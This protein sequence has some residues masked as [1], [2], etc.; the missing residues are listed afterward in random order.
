MIDNHIHTE[1]WGIYPALFKVGN[2]EISSY[3]FFVLL[4]LI[5]GLITYYLLTK[6]MNQLGEKSFYIVVAGVVGGIL[7][8]KLPYWIF[9]F[10]AIIDHYPD[11]RPILTG[12]TITGGLIGGTLSVMYI[13]SRLGIREKRGNLFA[14]A[15]AI[16]FAIGRIGC[17]LRGCCYG[18]PTDLFFGMDFGDDIYRHPTQLYEIAYFSGF[19]IFSL[20]RIK[21]SPPGQLFNLLINSYFIFRFFEEF[22]RYNESL[23]FGLSFFQYISILALVFINVKSY[24]EKKPHYGRLLS[25]QETKTE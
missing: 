18:T 22:I 23:Y 11:I 2:I 1:N 19:F 16:G 8:A 5:A 4:G 12:R 14:P 24:L 10:Q 13:K 6:K 9:N 15:I 17:L 25:K 20:S 3:S 21:T 7:G